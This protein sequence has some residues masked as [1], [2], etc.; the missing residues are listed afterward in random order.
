MP[1]VGETVRGYKLLAVTEFEKE[2]SVIVRNATGTFESEMV[3]ACEAT[4][5]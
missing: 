3:Y 4:G 5:S 2:A 1:M